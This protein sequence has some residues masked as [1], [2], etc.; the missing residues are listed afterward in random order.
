MIKIITVKKI[1][2]N[3]F[4]FIKLLWYNIYCKNTVI[5][6]LRWDILW[7]TIILI[8]NQKSNWKEK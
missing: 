3:I 6:F 4:D 2:L 5:I 1:L 8:K 7:I